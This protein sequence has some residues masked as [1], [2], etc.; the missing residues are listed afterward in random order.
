MTRP[1]VLL[2]DDNFAVAAEMRDLLEPSATI[3]GIVASGEELEA[4]CETLAPEVIVT[5]I[6]MPGEGGLTA[7]EHIRRRHPEVR[8]VLLTVSDSPSIIR[9]GLKLG[10]QGYVVKAD[11]GDELVPAL[12]AAV[13]GHRYV[14][15]T[16][17]GRLPSAEV[18]G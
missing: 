1:R 12:Q 6:E 18:E 10:I 16:A 8:V 5:D 15:A 14:S 3:V 2:A 11:A 9:L 17:R 13:A 7:V 4:A